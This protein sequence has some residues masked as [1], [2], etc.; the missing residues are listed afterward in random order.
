MYTMLVFY[1]C[2]QF[3]MAVQAFPVRYAAAQGMTF[4]TIGDSLILGMWGCKTSR[5]YQRP[6]ATFLGKGV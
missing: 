4:S 2:R 1:P 5:T 3:I 6:N